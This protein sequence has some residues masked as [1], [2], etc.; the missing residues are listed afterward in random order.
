MQQWKKQES[1]CFSYGECQAKYDIDEILR[2]EEQDEILAELGDN[3]KK[4]GKPLFFY[5]CL[6]FFLNIFRNAGGKAAKTNI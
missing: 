3:Q 2:E 4:E 6:I 1:P 5:F